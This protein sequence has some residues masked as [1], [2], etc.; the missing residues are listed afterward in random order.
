MWKLYWILATLLIV[1]QAFGQHAENKDIIR[2]AKNYKDYMFRNN[3]DKKVLQQLK[4][5]FSKTLQ[6]ETEFI[7]QTLTSQNKLLQEKFLTTPSEAVL[8]NIYIIR[9]VNLNLRKESQIDNN[10]L[11]DSLNALKTPRYE[12][13][14][15]YYAMLFTGVGNKNKP[16]NLSKVDLQLDTYNLKDDV[17]QGILFLQCMKN[18]GS[19]IWGFM[20]IV[21]PPNTAKALDLINKYPKVNSRP[22]YQFTDLY[23]KDFE[24]EIIVDEGKQSYKSFYLDKYYELLLSH[25]I[26]LNKEGGTEEE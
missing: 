20:N 10:Q 9:E 11:I 17:E 18:C 12:L 7:I 8:K 5:D 21:K 19:F 13:I 2:L 14:D 6:T 3:P 25:L 22:Y 1:N 16:F 4:K 26:C 23:F 15:N 24:M